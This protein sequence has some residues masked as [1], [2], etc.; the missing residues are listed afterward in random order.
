MK[1]IISSLCW[2]MKN[3]AVTNFWTDV[4]KHDAE[5][6]KDRPALYDKLAAIRTYKEQG[7]F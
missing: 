5:I 1:S 7:K 2:R 3:I 6:R 4:L